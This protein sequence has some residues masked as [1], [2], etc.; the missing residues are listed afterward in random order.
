MVKLPFINEMEEVLRNEMGTVALD[1]KFD[2]KLPK[3]VK[4]T[5]KES[6]P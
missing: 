5:D 3:K 6:I 4:Q 1:G 2:F